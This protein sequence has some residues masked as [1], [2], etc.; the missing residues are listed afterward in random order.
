MQIL[1]PA[2]AL[3]ALCAVST[4]ALAHSDDPVRPTPSSAYYSVTAQMRVVSPAPLEVWANRDTEERQHDA[5]TFALLRRGR[6]AAQPDTTPMLLDDTKSQR[7]GAQLASLLFDTGDG[8]C[9]LLA[10]DRPRVALCAL[11]ERLGATSRRAS[12]VLPMQTLAFLPPSRD[13]AEQ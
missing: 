6:T 12:I 3:I 8:L 10:K 7:S 11:L 9:A 1:R 4:S 5:M 2:S 13:A